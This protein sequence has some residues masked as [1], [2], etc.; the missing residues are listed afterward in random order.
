M[1]FGFEEAKQFCESHDDPRIKSLWKW[2]CESRSKN[3][4]WCDALNSEQEKTAVMLKAL[5]AIV[6]HQDIAGGSMAKLS[7]T[8]FI[9]A[10]AIKKTTGEVV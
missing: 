1:V 6:Q 2:L 9:A 5:K 10:D 7:T 3:A 8:R 4:Q